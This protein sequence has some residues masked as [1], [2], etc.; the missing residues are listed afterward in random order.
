MKQSGLESRQGAN[1]FEHFFDDCIRQHG[2]SIFSHFHHLSLCF[3]V[4]FFS[5][6]KAPIDVDVAGYQVVLKDNDGI[7]LGRNSMYFRA[8]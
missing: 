7:I 3:A 5:Q 2:V 4:I 1:G 8:C 6:L